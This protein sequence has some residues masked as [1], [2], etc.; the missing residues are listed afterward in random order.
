MNVVF[1]YLFS[2]HKIN[3]STEV[4]KIDRDK[5]NLFPFYWAFTTIGCAN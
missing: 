5:N 1:L 2:C 3:I 4:N